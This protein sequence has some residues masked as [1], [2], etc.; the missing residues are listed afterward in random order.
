MNTRLKVYQACVTSIL[1]YR[2]E[3][4][5]PTGS[6]TEFI[7]STLPQT[8]S[9]YLLVRQNSKHHCAGE[10]Q[11]LSIYALISQRRLGWLEHICRMEMEGFQR[12]FSTV[13]LKRVH[14]KWVAHSFA[15]KMFARGI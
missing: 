8:N 7:P 6:K 12:T 13:T 11:M 14:V 1:L 5:T 9:A 3:M 2:S 4:W 15:S 10:G